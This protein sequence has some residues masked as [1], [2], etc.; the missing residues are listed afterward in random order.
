MMT[1][2]QTDDGYDQYPSLMLAERLRHRFNDRVSLKQSVVVTSA[3][4]EPERYSLASKLALDT[5]LNSHLS[6][7]CELES[8]Y[9]NLPVNGRDHHDLLLT[10]GV[11]LSF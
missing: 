2:E 8:R 11:A 10:T 5:K 1:F 6:W 7:R 4:D 9:E 3:F